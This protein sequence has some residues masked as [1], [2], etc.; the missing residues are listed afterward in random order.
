MTADEIKRIIGKIPEGVPYMI[1]GNNNIE[2]YVGNREC[3]YVLFDDTNN[4]VINFRSNTENGDIRYKKPIMSQ[5]V[6]YDQ[7]QRICTL[8]SFNDFKKYLDNLNVSEE[9]R[10]KAIVALAPL[11]KANINPFSNT[12]KTLTT[13]EYEKL[14][15][16]R[17]KESKN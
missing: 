7:I 12:N 3:E 13:E 2:L 16:E 15:K 9:E 17:E 6:P 1:E 11:T 10:T 8:L 14:V 5:A 4:V